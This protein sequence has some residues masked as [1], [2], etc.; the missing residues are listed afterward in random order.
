MDVSHGARLI[1]YST[2]L[3]LE[4]VTILYEGLTVSNMRNPIDRYVDN[5]FGNQARSVLCTRSRSLLNVRQT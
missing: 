3:C 5:Y 1:S 4:S 2:F